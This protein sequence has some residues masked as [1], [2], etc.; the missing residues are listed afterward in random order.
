MYELPDDGFN[1][2]RNM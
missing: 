1:G 2:N